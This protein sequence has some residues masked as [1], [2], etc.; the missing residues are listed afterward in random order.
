M[1]LQKSKSRG[2]AYLSIVQSYREKDTGKSKARTIKSLGYL[3]VLEKQYIDPIAHF[4]AVVEKMNQE[5]AAKN[6]PISIRI[7]KTEIL[8]KNIR[9]RK[10]IGYA[11]LSKIYHELGLHVFMN[12]RARSFG[13]EYSPNSIMKL[14]VYSRILYPGSKKKTHENREMFFEDTN[15]SLDDVYR[16]LTFFNKLRDDIQ[17]HLHRKITEYYERSTDLVYYDV[18]NYYFEIDE[19]DE[20]RKKGISKEHRPDPIIQMG[21]FMDTMGIPISY[22][23]FPGN[24]NDCETLVP[25][26]AKMKRDYNIGRTIVVADK[27][28]NTSNNIVFNTLRHDG[29]VYSQT[30]RGGNK[31]LKIFVL[32]EN[33][34]A[35]QGDDYKIKSR[36]YPRTIN[37][38]TATG[39][40]KKVPIDEK[41]VIFYSRAYDKKAKADREAAIIKARDL[42]K[43]PAKY[44]RATSYGAARFVKNLS[45]DKKTGE[46]ITVG[47]APFFDEAKLCEEEKYD[48]YYAIVTSEYKKSDSEIIDIYRGLW[49]I[50][51][52]FKVTKSDLETRPVYLSREE[53]IQAHF[54]LC[55]ISLVIARC[56][57]IRLGNRF[58]IT[59]IAESLRQSACSHVQDNYYLLDHYDDVTDAIGEAFGIHINKKFLSLGE[60]KNILGASKEA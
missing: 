38:K 57:E 55:F 3:D 18:T 32:D 50:E 49:K 37:V 34:Y 60:I 24:T 22:G 17:K 36:S 42:V 10:N 47:Q 7:N 20:L 6:I 1:H 46:V 23:L 43:N 35:W 30:V 8:D 41:Q 33:G 45:F 52:S 19:Q 40:T 14:L 26:M 44:T 9:N 12:N 5:E 54:L 48:G 53:H 59:R 29:Y 39:Q 13:A 4:K 27:G 15:F 25:L 58:S 56:L 31:E 28:L 16:S 51:E 11:A 2:R 21:L